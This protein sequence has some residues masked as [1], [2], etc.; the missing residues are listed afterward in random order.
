MIHHVAGP[1]YF[2][3][4][5]VMKSLMSVLA[6]VA[7]GAVLPTDV[8]AFQAPPISSGGGMVLQEI[9]SGNQAFFC[10]DPTGACDESEVT[11]TLSGS[12]RVQGLE[13]GDTEFGLEG[14]VIK[15]QICTGGECGPDANAGGGTTFSYVE[16][17]GNDQQV[18]DFE[19]RFLVVGISIPPQP[20]IG[21][22]TAYKS[23]YCGLWLHAS[24]GQSDLILMPSDLYDPANPSQRFAF[25]ESGAVV[26]LRGSLR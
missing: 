23:Y 8:A 22:P 24:D 4:R 7:V 12:M 25:A 18:F 10:N 13:D 14:V 9:Q 26:E 16:W 11:H 6:I 21:G 5:G 19:H 15:C 17:E 2:T 3:R 1:G 20:P